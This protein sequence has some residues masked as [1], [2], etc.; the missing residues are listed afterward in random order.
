[1]RDRATNASLV[2]A[3]SFLAT[4]AGSA[5]QVASFDES[6][7][8]TVSTARSA[9]ECA[10]WQALHPDWIF[11][12]DFED[13]TALVRAGRWFEHD[14][15]DGEFAVRDGVGVEESRGMRG[16]WQA[17][18]VGAGSL[19]LGFGRNP[20]RYMQK[21]I[22]PDEDFREIYYRMYLRMQP[23]WEGEPAKLSRATIFTSSE[24]WRQAMIAHLWST[25]PAHL[26]VD[27]ARCVDA[28]SRV[29][30][31]TY[32]DFAKLDWLGYQR[33]V[34]PLFDAAHADT[35]LCVEAH[36]RLNDPG[37]ANG[38]QEFWVDGRLEARREGL[39]FVRSYT[40][41][42]LNAVFFEN[43][44]NDGS[45]KEQERYFDNI[46][47]SRRPIGC[48]AGA[49]PSPTPR[50]ATPSPGPATETATLTP[51]PTSSTATPT[52][53]S[54]AWLAFLPAMWR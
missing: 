34:T 23:G 29:K 43:Y 38:V 40:D 44:W 27:P 16:R 6:G 50:T 17:D 52:G 46:V 15:N 45:P 20:N 4:E 7:L 2:V 10:D 8:G 3:A 48:L 1:L 5:R 39:D 26:L 33:G 30:C 49:A 36:V 53:S 54:V 25:T 13:D 14:D 12:D 24:D 11:C 51:T 37:A 22:R 19:K 32:N 41:Y 28:Q 18:E 21:G 42:A 9:A 47:V 31:T 35:W